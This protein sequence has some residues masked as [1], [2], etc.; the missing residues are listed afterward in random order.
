MTVEAVRDIPLILQDLA[1]QIV[2]R[3]LEGAQAEELAA[4]QAE[5]DDAR[6]GM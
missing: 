3:R 4:L 5:Y 2:R 1:E 6:R